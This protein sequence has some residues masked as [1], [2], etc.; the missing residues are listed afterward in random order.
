MLEIKGHIF[1]CCLFLSCS[2]GVQI[3]YFKT[4]NEFQGHR[5]TK[6]KKK[7]KVWRTF[8]G[9]G[10]GK[11]WKL[12]HHLQYFHSIRTWLFSPF[13]IWEVILKVLI[14]AE[15]V[16]SL[17]PRAKTIPTLEECLE[18]P[19]QGQIAAFHSSPLADRKCIMTMG[20]ELIRLQDRQS[21]H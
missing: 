13:K 1:N 6:N 14:I 9:S 15:H 4:L 18:H 19:E 12:R 5:Y 21:K 11:L 2:F 20:V 17:N 7:R 3:C 8:A 10:N 16:T